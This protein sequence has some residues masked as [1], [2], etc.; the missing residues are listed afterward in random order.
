[1]W[2]RVCWRKQLRLEKFDLGKKES[3]LFPPELSVLLLSFV[4]VKLYSLTKPPGNL[5]GLSSSWKR[6]CRRRPKLIQKFA[7][8]QGFK[9]H[10]TKQ[11][12]NLASTWG[13]SPCLPGW[14]G[15]PDPIRPCLSDRSSCG[16]RP[17]S[18]GNVTL[19]LQV[20]SQYKKKWK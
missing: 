10:E 4:A 14:C 12:Q 20:E 2:V 18:T 16:T 1:M 17:Q 11:L 7:R 3:A 13:W 5:P 15:W 19:P 9:K 8:A 6:C